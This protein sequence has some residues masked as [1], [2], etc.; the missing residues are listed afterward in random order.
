MNCLYHGKEM[1]HETEI[2]NVGVANDADFDDGIEI[3]I[4]CQNRSNSMMSSF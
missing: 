4:Y 3:R 2:L 1:K